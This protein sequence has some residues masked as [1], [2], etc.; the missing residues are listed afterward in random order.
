MNKKFFFII[1]S[2]FTYFCD[3]VSAQNYQALRDS[4]SKATEA[5]SYKPD[6]LDLRLKKQGGIYFLNSGNM[7]VTSMTLY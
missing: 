5:L 3:R 7:P 2:I 4:L 1:L 6:S